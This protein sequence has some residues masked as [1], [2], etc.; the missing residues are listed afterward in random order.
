MKKITL[1]F[2]GFICI[3]TTSVFGQT[4]TTGLIQLNTEPGLE[5]SA[6]IDVTG[7]QVTLTLNAPSDR[8]FGFGFDATS[9]TN[10]KDVVIFDGTD[11]TDRSFLYIGVVPPMDAEQDWTIISNTVSGGTRTL[12]ATRPSNTGNAN[13]Y[14]FTTSANSI[15]L[16]WSMADAS[17]FSVEFANYHFNNYG[18]TMQSF[19]LSQ[20]EFS[21]AE[22]SLSPNPAKSK[23]KIFLPRVYNNARLDVFDVLGKKIYSKEITQLTSVIDVSKWNNGLY[24]VRISTDEATQTKRFVKQ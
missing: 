12:V 11:L 10:G 2:L 24:L 6:Q 4:N 5:Y 14:V 16:V 23:F 18:V 20:D 15:N 7:S 8:W 19:T 22:F 17:N 1:A 3:L 21:T 9:M 13:D